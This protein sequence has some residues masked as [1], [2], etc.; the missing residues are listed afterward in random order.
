MD[1]IGRLHS[2]SQFSNSPSS[3][4]PPLWLWPVFIAEQAVFYLLPRVLLLQELPA[5]CARTRAG[6]L[7]V[8]TLFIIA[9]TTSA[10]VPYHYSKQSTDFQGRP[11]DRT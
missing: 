7:I 2:A 5:I 3:T 8:A 10:R 1:R 11:A 6:L 4:D 9:A